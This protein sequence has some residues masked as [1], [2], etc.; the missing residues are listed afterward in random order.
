MLRKIFTFVVMGALT[1]CMFGCSSAQSS[2]SAKASKTQSSGG[3]EASK[4]QSSGQQASSGEDVVYVQ[5]EPDTISTES[6]YGDG[7]AYEYGITTS[8]IDSSLPGDIVTGPTATS[9]VDDGD[10][11][12]IRGISLYVPEGVQVYGRGG[13]DKC[14][15]LLPGDISK[16]EISAG[17][18]EDLGI[19]G[20]PEAWLE[21]EYAD[22]AGHGKDIVL[23]SSQMGFCL[24]GDV[25]EA[26]FAG[27]YTG[28]SLIAEALIAGDDGT[29]YRFSMAYPL[30]AEAA[31]DSNIAVEEI[32]EA[33]GTLS[34]VLFSA[35]PVAE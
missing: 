7:Y 21:G 14:S 32:N 34:T 25:Y 2:G 10:T 5:P 18:P 20:T 9:W 22:M 26:V 35:A 12:E 3:A 31:S 1:L 19:Y 17:T 29:Y 28:L 13:D 30:S 4:T 11:V 15:L 24:A 33:W 27:D 8:S 16:I 6:G 23:S